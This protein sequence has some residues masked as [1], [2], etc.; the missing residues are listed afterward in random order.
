MKTP[1]SATVEDQMALALITRAVRGNV[2]AIREVL[3]SVYGKIKD[4]HEITRQDG[5]P[6]TIIQPTVEELKAK[7]EEERQQFE[8]R[9]QERM[10]QV[11][12]LDDD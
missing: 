4:Q 8:L 7:W 1:P 9:Q 2:P 5:L 12:N 3:D 11:A 10:R 6:I